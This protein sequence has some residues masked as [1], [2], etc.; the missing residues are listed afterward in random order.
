MSSNKKKIGRRTGNYW[1]HF[2]RGE[3]SSDGHARATCKFCGYSMY[4]GESSKMLGHIAN[5]CK[6]APGLVVREYLEKFSETETET[7]TSQNK[8]RKA[9]VSGNTQSI[10]E[11]SFRKV[12]ELTSG[13]V[14]QINRALIRFFVCCGVSFRIVESPFFVEL[15]KLLN[16]SYT[17]PS[18][19]LLT[20]RLMEE[21]LSKVNFK[22]AEELKNEN[23]LTLGKF[24]FF[25]F[26]LIINFINFSLFSPRWVD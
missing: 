15:L 5:H 17:P 12:E 23:N 25:K 8:K 14:N 18:R 9:T 22:V 4:R 1:E 20:G 24:F 2:E 7:G 11:Q 19:E 10:L 26:F 16:P 6:E 3:V 21:E 13:Y